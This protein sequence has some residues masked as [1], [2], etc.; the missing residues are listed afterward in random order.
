MRVRLSTEDDWEQILAIYNEAVE[1]GFLTADLSPV[2]IDSRRSWFKLHDGDHYPIYVEELGN[3]IRGWCSLSPYRE[4]RMALRQTAEISY[5]ISP[6]H[7][8]QGVATRLIQHALADTTRLGIRTVFGI[9]L[10]TN[11]GSLRLLENLGFEKWG[12]LPGVA[13]FDGE[14]C[15]HVYMGRRV[16]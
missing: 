3:E 2:D 11:E 5:Y 14:E 8:R 15:G 1:A 13:N 12:H 4:G 16:N 7:Q 6:T 10:E 9:I